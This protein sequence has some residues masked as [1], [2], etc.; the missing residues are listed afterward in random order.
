FAEQKC[1]LVILET[2][3]GGMLDATNVI[4]PLISVITTISLDHEQYLGERVEAVAFEK[5][6]IIKTGIPV[7]SGVLE[8]SAREVIEDICRRRKAPLGTRDIDF[9]MKPVEGTDFIW[10][11]A[12]DSTQIAVATNG[13][14]GAWQIDNSSC[15]I[16]AAIALRE[17]GFAVGDGAIIAGI[18]QASWPGRMEY[19]EVPAENLAGMTSKYPPSSNVRFLLDGAHN[20]AGVTYLI[21]TLKSQFSFARLFVIWASMADKNYRDMLLEVAQEADVLILTLPDSERAALPKDLAGV[22]A[23]TD[24]NDIL[25]TDSVAEALKSVSAQ[26][27]PDD[28]IVAAGSLYLIGEFRSLLIGE[29]V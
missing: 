3:M 14:R 13:K 24:R 18:A 4:T 28:L 27:T 21:D 10:K 20:Q 11:T 8:G 25:I 16:A 7:I 9:F 6:G 5:A 2:G 15:T 1:D 26:A 12:D 23:G 29:V 22:F 17:A 19:L